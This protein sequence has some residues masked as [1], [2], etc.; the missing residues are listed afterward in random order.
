QH[1]AFLVMEL[2]SGGTLRDLLPSTG[3]LDV[4][5]ALSVVEPVLAALAAAH[6]AGLAHRDIKPENILI[7]RSLPVEGTDGSEQVKVADFGLA[8]AAAGTNSTGSDTILGTVAYLAPEQV[9]SAAAG[10][11]G[12]VYSTG[13][14]LYEMLTGAPPYDGDTALSVAYRHVHDDVPA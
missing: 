11:A 6:H 12:D 5:T 14:V 7:S 2:V 10:P 8:R 3:A 9:T 13:I 1:L 4:H